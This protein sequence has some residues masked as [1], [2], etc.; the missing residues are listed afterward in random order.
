M[1]IYEFYCDDCNTI[2]SFIASRVNTTKVPGCPKCNKDL[3]RRMSI[4]ATAGRAREPGEDGLPDIDEGRMEQVLASLA[5]EAE[6]VNEDDPRQMAGVMRKFT[7][8]TGLSLGDGMEEALSRM[9]AG[10]DPEKIEAEMGDIL[11]NEDPLSM[12]A[13]KALKTGRRVAPAHDEK[14]FEL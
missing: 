13:Q 11:E 3:A 4:F 6:N 7:Q 12:F 2:F 9:E 1:P 10:D 8:K 14:I 5:R